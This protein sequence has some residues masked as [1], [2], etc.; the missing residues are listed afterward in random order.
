M[1]KEDPQRWETVPI[2]FKTNFRDENGYA[3][4]RTSIY[5]HDALEKEF[6]IDIKDR[7]FLV[8]DVE[9]AYFVVTQHH[10]AI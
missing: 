9:G 6:L 3:D 8:T 1:R 7:N 5:I 2:T 10:D 4:I